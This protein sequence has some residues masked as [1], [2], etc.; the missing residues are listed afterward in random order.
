MPSN[1]G[2]D[3]RFAII[4]IPPGP[5]PPEAIMVGNMDAVMRC[6][7]QSVA[8]EEQEQRLAQAKEEAAETEQH[9]AEVRACALQILG[10][11][12]E[13]LSGRLDAF[14][15]NRKAREEQ[16]HRDAEAAEAKAIEAYL[17]SLPDPEFPQAM[18]DEGE[19]EIKEPP[20]VEKYHPE[21][22]NEAISGALPEELSEG[23]PPETGEFGAPLPPASPYRDPTA[24]GGN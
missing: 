21:A 17:A 2:P 14:E 24:I 11:G 22:R 18:S 1:P 7:P 4:E 16:A 12:L 3:A 15:A 23:S 13:H 10:D 8:N 9:Q 6:L 19:F 20:D 5:S